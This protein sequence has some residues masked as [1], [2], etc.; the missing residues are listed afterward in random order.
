[1]AGRE[2]PDR[3][4]SGPRDMFTVSGGAQRGEQWRH[5]MSAHRATRAPDQPGQGFDGLGGR[6]VTQ[7]IGQLMA[8][9]DPE[10]LVDPVEVVFDGPDGEMQVG[11]DLL[12]GATRSGLP[13][14]VELDRC[15]ASTGR[16][17]CE[18]G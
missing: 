10:L 6:L 8:P 2:L 11:G 3:P 15:A 13:G 18:Q 9:G 5:A 4:G 12:V 1:M 14:G 16:E 7:N 17:V